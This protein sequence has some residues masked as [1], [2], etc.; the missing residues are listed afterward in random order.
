MVTGE[1]V[2]REDAEGD[3]PRGLRPDLTRVLQ[4][5][6]LPTALP[7]LPGARLAARYATAGSALS[8]GGDWY[9]AISL[10]DGR[11]ALSV[12]DVVGSGPAAAAVMGQLRSALSAYLLAGMEL[13]E[14]ITRLGEFARRVP[15]AAGA[16]ACVAVLDPA[17]GELSYTS[18]A[19]PPIV[20]A[21][22]GAK[23]VFLPRAAGNPLALGDGDFELRRAL[24][25]PGDLVVLYSDGAVDRSGR[26]PQ[27]GAAGLLA[28]AA[29]I[30][31][32]Q[33]ATVD[34]CCDRLL[35]ALLPAGPPV[36]DLALLLLRVREPHAPL[37]RTVPGRSDQLGVLRRELRDWLAER[38]IDG[39][40][41][42]AVQIAVGEATAN[43]VEHAY[44]G[45]ESG[46]VTL[47]AELDPAGTLLLSITDA[48]SW[49]VPEEDP[50]GRGRGLLLMQAA[51][52]SVRVRHSEAG[53]TVELRR[54]LGA[55]PGREVEPGLDE[56]A[57]AI[58]TGPDGPV[59]RLRGVVDS[60]TVDLLQPVLRRTGRGGA[61]E[62]TVD[63]AQVGYLASAGVKMFFELAAEAA[64]AGG[65][66]VLCAPPG[67]SAGYVAR[68]TG[69]DAY[70]EVRTR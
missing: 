45:S 22:P 60:T 63:L 29:E 1:R 20:R 46:P 10:G 23:A 48:G 49:R 28:C 16:T 44:T 43:A 35:G 4:D 51:M 8:A 55:G 58:E 17:L 11:L 2:G 5:S 30:A 53:T 61:L 39:E 12:G 6:L 70:V 26:P 31:A 65:R 9:D 68:L 27:R 56:L 50:R 47:T 40:D 24:V 54:R 62:L 67:T 69:L 7:V 34:A 19:H 14:V 66:L 64:A 57:V 38:E 15:G 36:D 25:E 3:L 42:L 32:D 18:A 52:D 33:E 21:R 41:A 59:V 37:N 13:A